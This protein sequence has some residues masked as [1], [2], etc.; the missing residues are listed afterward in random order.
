MK[1]IISTPSE[2]TSKEDLQELT[3]DLCRSLN[4]SIDGKAVL[5]QQSAGPGLRGEPITIGMIMLTFLTSGAAT[6]L[7]NVFKSYFERNSSLEMAFERDDGKKFVVRA[8]NLNSDAIGGTIE[9]ADKF[10]A[11]A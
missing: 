5:P 10:L 11:G 2:E 6:A 9:L 7:F 3:L 4:R 8:E 1:L